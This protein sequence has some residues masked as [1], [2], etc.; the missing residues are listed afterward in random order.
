MRR[1][2]GNLEDAVPCC[3]EGMVYDRMESGVDTSSYLL[4]SDRH[5]FFF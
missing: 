3:Q 2:R 4:A 5:V 1:V